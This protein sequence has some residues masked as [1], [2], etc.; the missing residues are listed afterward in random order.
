MAHLTLAVNISVRQMR[1][2][3]FVEQVLTTSVAPG[4]ILKSYALNLPK[5]CS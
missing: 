1:H 2:H 3:C 5:A 4:P